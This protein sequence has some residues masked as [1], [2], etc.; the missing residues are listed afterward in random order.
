MSVT[1]NEATK[2]V[3]VKDGLKAIF[4]SE[5]LMILALINAL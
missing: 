4:S 5:V 1:Y 3:D 2:S